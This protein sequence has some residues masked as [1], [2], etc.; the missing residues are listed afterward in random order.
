MEKIIN[1]FV[2]LILVFAMS[3]SAIAAPVIDEGS[4]GCS[5]GMFSVSGTASSGELLMLRAIKPGADESLPSSIFYAEIAFAETDGTFSFDFGIN[6]G[7][8]GDY[9]MIITSGDIVSSDAYTV[10]GINIADLMSAI[11][12][13]NSAADADVLRDVFDNHKA[14]KRIGLDTAIYG[15]I[16][17]GNDAATFD[18][19]FD[20]LYNQ[21]EAANLGYDGTEI[22]NKATLQNV[23]DKSSALAYLN[24]ENTLAALEEFNTP[25]FFNLATTIQTSLNSYVTDKN[26]VKTLVA[27]KDYN[28]I[29]DLQ[30]AY[31]E[32]LFLAAIKSNDRF[33]VSNIVNAAGV[34][35]LLG[36]SFKLTDYNNSSK[37]AADI[38]VAGKDFATLAEFIDTFN[39]NIPTDS[40]SSYDGDGGG[41]GGFGGGSSI[42][43]GAGTSTPVVPPYVDK[44]FYDLAGYEWAK[45]SIEALQG[46]NII[47]G[48]APNAFSPERTV[49]REEF[50]KM[51]VL[52]AGKYNSSAAAAFGDVP[53]SHWASSY[54][55]SA[56]AAGLVQGIDANNFGT[57]MEISRQDACVLLARAISYLEAFDDGMEFTDSSL[58]SDYAAEAVAFLSSLGIINGMDDGSFAPLSSM[59]RAQA[60]KVLYE[61]YKIGGFAD[62]K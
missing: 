59:T 27:A 33:Q 38:A 49:T 23:L 9:K 61:I 47:S 41:G 19:I 24:Q 34:A 29:S 8:T 52:L 48:T 36:G 10:A 20:N 7:A 31:D 43:V 42:G 4:S 3:L 62:E 28:S 22:V 35:G 55:A 21:K 37:S 6:S 18:I 13:I 57:G 51:L 46:M 44:S 14:A 26:A 53:A 16:L 40:G 30:R 5:A 54:I 50:V 11:R 58:I 60:A 39:K 32:K 17:P 56:A 15:R 1:I 45:E 2:S 12:Q 25:G